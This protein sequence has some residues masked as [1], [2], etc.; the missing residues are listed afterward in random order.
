MNPGPPAPQA[1]VIIRQHGKYPVKLELT[2]VLDDEPR[3]RRIQHQNNK[4]FG[5]NVME[6]QPATQE[7]TN[8]SETTAISS[9]QTLSMDKTKIQ[10]LPVH[11]SFGSI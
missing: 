3:I 10:A 8:T 1:G 6:K 4:D 5:T 2:I 9:K 7:S 11:A